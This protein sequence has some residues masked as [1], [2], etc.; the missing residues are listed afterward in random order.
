MEKMSL[1]ERVRKNEQAAISET[2]DR[3]WNDCIAFVKRNNGSEQHAEDNYQDT[4]MAFLQKLDEGKVEIATED[5]SGVDAYLRGINKFMWL[6]Y[7]RK[8]AK[9][10]YE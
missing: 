1:L 4:W 10:D 8:R 6:G 9:A 7:I 5:A 3:N 2:Y